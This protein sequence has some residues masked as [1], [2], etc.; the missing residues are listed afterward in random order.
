MSL[1]IACFRALCRISV[2]VYIEGTHTR[3]GGT[4]NINAKHYKENPDY[5]AAVIAYQY[6]QDIKSQVGYRDVKIKKV[7]CSCDKDITELTKRIE[8]LLPQDNLPF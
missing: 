4:F 7:V 1:R 8:P 6:I 5:A 3:S 2:N